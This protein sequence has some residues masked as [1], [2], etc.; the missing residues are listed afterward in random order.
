MCVCVYV[1]FTC[2][3]LCVRDY[4]TI[5]SPIGRLLFSRIGLKVL[6]I[7]DCIFLEPIVIVS[8]PSV[9]GEGRVCGC[10]LLVP[11]TSRRTTTQRIVWSSGLD[12]RTNRTTTD[13]F[14]ELTLRLKESKLHLKLFHRF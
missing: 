11:L 14:R 3:Y 6:D 2:V 5:F 9:G 12:E 4:K 7:G 8:S 1:S 13:G 10:G